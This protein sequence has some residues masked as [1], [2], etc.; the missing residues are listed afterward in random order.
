MA[1]ILSRIKLNVRQVAAV[2]VFVIA[3]AVPVLIVVV[4]A[5]IVGANR[6]STKLRRKIGDINRC[7][8]ETLEDVRVIHAFNRQKHEI[9]RFGATSMRR[10]N[11]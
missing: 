7:I 3:V 4:T 1:D 5:L 11:G 6:Y 9:D 8:L 10:C 2:D